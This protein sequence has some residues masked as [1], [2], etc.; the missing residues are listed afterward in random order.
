MAQPLRAPDALEEDPGLVPSTCRWLL[1]TISDSRSRDLA[2]S[3]GLLGTWHT[4]NMH[5]YRQVE[6][7]YS[8]TFDLKNQTNKQ[9]NKQTRVQGN[10]KEEL[11]CT[12]AMSFLP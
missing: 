11:L 9:T 5:E 6:R 10:C 8:K 7:P 3:S 2:P 1:I 4:C 12:P